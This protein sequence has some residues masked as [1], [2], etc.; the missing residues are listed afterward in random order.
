MESNRLYYY[1]F[2]YSFLLFAITFFAAPLKDLFDHA[3][4]MP[5]W[6]EVGTFGTIGCIFLGLFL[7]LKDKFA[8][9]ELGG[10][11][12]RIKQNGV[13]A[14]RYWTEVE[15]IVQINGVTPPLY[16]LRIK[17]MPGYIL[18]N[19]D[20]FISF[21]GLFIEDTSDMGTLIAKKKRELDI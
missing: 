13:L 17:G 2:K 10:Q 20:S 5:S 8:I 12:I 3:A 7:W 9:V 4:A 15:S 19:T 1:A 14:E 18:F 16:Q 21:A 11:R 6:I